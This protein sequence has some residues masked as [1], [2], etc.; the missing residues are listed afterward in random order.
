MVVVS[1]GSDR[2]HVLTLGSVSKMRLIRGQ[3][4]YTG[5]EFETFLFNN[6]FSQPYIYTCIEHFKFASTS[7]F[8]PRHTL[9]MNSMVTARRGFTCHDNLCLIQWYQ[10]F[11]LP[12]ILISTY[13]SI[14]SSPESSP[15]KPLGR[16]K[17]NFLWNHLG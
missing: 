4:Y 7:F 9:L 15:L 1:I 6:F 11:L 8:C 16:S 3:C 14:I 2:L 5:S 10:F 12:Y 17:P 13:F